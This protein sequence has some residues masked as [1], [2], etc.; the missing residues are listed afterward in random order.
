M[1]TTPA[2]A[3]WVDGDP[4]M[5]AIAAAVWEQCITENSIVVDDPRTIAAVA[6]TVARQILGT[7]EPAPV[8]EV[9]ESLRRDGFGDDEISDVFAATGEQGPK[10]LNTADR[11]AALGM[12]PTEYRAHSHRTAVQQIREAAR[13]LYFETGM[14]VLDALDT[15]PAVADTQP[16]A[17]AHR[18]LVEYIAEVLEA[19]GVW[20]YLGA[21]PDRSVAEKR[22]ASV[23]RRHPDAKTRTVRKTTT[24]TVAAPAVTEEPGR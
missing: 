10:G 13:G 15:A 20:M 2:P 7:A 11:A 24:Y 8:D 18:P 22:R 17:E 5:Q 6:A 14:R 23:T 12:T 1:T 4:L 16:E 3:V 9:A 19:D 21:D